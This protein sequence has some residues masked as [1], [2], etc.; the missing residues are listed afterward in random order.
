MA[1]VNVSDY[2]LWIKHIHGDDE[3]RSYLDALAPD[4]TVSLR[5]AGEAGV[6]RKMSAYKT[7]GRPTPGL[8]PLGPAQALWKELYK[9]NKARG[10]I[11]VEIE[12]V[13]E[14]AGAVGSEDGGDGRNAG[15]PAVAATWER[16]PQ[17]ERAAAWEAFKALRTAGWR[18]DGP[19]GT[20]DEWYAE[21]GR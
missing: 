13:S 16:A 7:T 21:E 15:A 19:Y 2:A 4:A 10:G 9:A 5:I 6:W 20:R 14:R 17:A 12:L 3:L 11:V 8:S 18:S 1:H